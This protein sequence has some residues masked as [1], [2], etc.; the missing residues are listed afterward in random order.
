MAPADDDDLQDDLY[1][2][3]FDFVDD[4]DDD[5]D[6][7]SAMDE[8]DSDEG[9]SDV[10]GSV[11][12]EEVPP[13][14]PRETVAKRSGPRQRRFD[15]EDRPR[16]E[17]RGPSGRNHDARDRDDRGRDDQRR[18]DR[19]RDD[20]GR[21]DRARDQRDPRD[22]QPRDFDQPD[23]LAADEPVEAPRDPEVPTNYRVHVY[24]LGEFKRTIDRPF[25]AEDA[26]L[27]ASEYN[28]TSKSYSRFA[29]TGKDDV[30]PRKLLSDAK[31]S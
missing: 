5:S 20:R 17:S 4:E 3:E 9:D 15:E 10:G 24:E 21:D 11:V 29:I 13:P 6:I 18:D 1:D 27:F 23:D 2:D 22:V 31:A 8:G 14:A 19:G 12:E 16:E 28:R 26:E 30:K 25:T 7:D